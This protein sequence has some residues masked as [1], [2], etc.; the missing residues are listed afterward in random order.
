M[1][2]AV[3]N[4]ILVPLD[5]SETSGNALTLAVDLSRRY[6]A[7]IHLLHIVKSYQC[8][9]ISENGLLIDFS[10]EAIKAAERKRLRRLA[11]EV[12][13][14]QSHACT[15]EC[16]VGNDTSNVIVEATV[17]NESDLI[18]MG[19]GT[20]GIMDFF[21]SSE[22]YD[23]VKAAPCPVLT[24]P[25]HWQ[26][27]KFK[28]ILFPVRSVE[29]ALE[30]YE[31]TKRLILDNNAQLTVLGLYN[32]ETPQKDEDLTELLSTLEHQLQQDKIKA[33]I[34]LVNTDEAAD[35]VLF[36][37]RQAEAD[38][39]IITADYEQTAGGFFVD[40]Y[41]RQII[42]QATVPVLAIRPQPFVVHMQPMHSSQT[43]M[44]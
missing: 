27:G 3:I 6:N 2:K 7:S 21:R 24:I 26:A 42:D 17:A 23:V 40:P 31:L 30:K 44:A 4:K 35:R 38:L 20:S 8:I 13:D 19:Q 37:S 32:E 11:D 39:I 25:A 28:K 22:T 16:C 12:T 5:Y 41:A 9:S 1:E 18:I 43:A 10:K 15:V 14:N 36:K 33:G 29:G 34:E